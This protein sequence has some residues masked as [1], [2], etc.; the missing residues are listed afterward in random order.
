MPRAREHAERALRLDPTLAETWASLAFVKGYYDWE[1]EAAEREEV[2]RR[3]DVLVTVTPSTSALVKRSWVRPGTHICAMGAD[4]KGKQELA[5][6]LVAAASVFVDS[7]EQAVTIGE[8]QHAP[9]R[10][11]VSSRDSG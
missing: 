8:C 7:V 3:A 10:L 5:P 4:T 6:D 1:W 9:G 11:R 2:A